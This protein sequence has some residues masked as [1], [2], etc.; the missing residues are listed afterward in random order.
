MPA[1]RDDT[2]NELAEAFKGFLRGT[3]HQLVAPSSAFSVMYV[4]I[5]TSLAVYTTTQDS[6]LW[7]SG[8][9]KGEETQIQYGES[10]RQIWFH[11]LCCTALKIRIKASEDPISL[12]CRFGEKVMLM[13]F[14]VVVMRCALHP[15][16][17]Y[18]TMWTWTTWLDRFWLLA[19]LLTLICGYDFRCSC[20]KQ[21][22]IDNRDVGLYITIALVLSTAAMGAFHMGW[23]G[24]PGGF[25]FTVP[26]LHRDYDFHA[27]SANVDGLR[28]ES[29]RIFTY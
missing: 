28:S 9:E 8:H 18:A 12:L 4:L 7:A 21:S 16:D 11:V 23:R 14:S 29:G 24:D 27:S 1:S 5:S 20:E 10:A 6:G 15:F 22:W 19:A 26:E 25:S 3:S 13:S 17:E 2:K